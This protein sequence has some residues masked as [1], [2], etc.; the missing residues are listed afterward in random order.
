MKIDLDT[1]HWIQDKE[2][3]VSY[4]YL[5]VEEGHQICHK[6]MRKTIAKE[7]RRRTKQ[8]LKTYLSPRNK[9]IV[10]VFQYSCGIINWSQSEIN[11]L[12]IKTRTFLT[13]HKTFHKNQCIPRMYLPRQEGGSG[14]MELNQ[15]HRGMSVGLAEYVKWSTDYRIQFVNKHEHNKL[16]TKT[17]PN[18]PCKEFPKAGGNRRYCTG[19][20]NG[21]KYSSNN[22]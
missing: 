20:W 14:L 8:I 22:C 10:P 4:K 13:I 18:S 6:Q 3:E 9:L 2:N 7:Y 21:N 12:D 17:I 16:K 11:K 5:G 15:V 1:I 19:K